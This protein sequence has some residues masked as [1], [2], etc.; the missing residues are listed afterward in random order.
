MFITTLGIPL[1]EGAQIEIYPDTDIT[2]DY[3]NLCFAYSTFL[4]QL[5]MHFTIILA[6]MMLF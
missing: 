2:K 5:T 3:T 1:F 6:I 4:K